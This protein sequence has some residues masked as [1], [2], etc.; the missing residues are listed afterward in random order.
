M[1]RQGGDAADEANA[2]R[3][4]GEIYKIM[5][6]ERGDSRETIALFTGVDESRLAQF[7]QG[8]LPADEADEIEAI[9]K[10][11]YEETRDIGHDLDIDQ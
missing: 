8:I 7:E 6:N 10:K 5:R 11:F 1:L 3:K 9:L 2:N 4:R